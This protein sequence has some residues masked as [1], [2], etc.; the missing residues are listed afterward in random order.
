MINVGLK[1]VAFLYKSELKELNKRMSLY[2]SRARLLGK[3]ASSSVYL[4]PACVAEASATCFFATATTFWGEKMRIVIP[5]I[6]SVAL[7]IF[8]CYEYELSHWMLKHITKGMTVVDVGA[9]IGYHTLLASFLVGD[10]GQVHSFEPTRGTFSILESNAR[11]R[12]NVTLNQKACFSTNTNT[13]LNDFGF[14]YSGFNTLAMP[15]LANLPKR[16]QYQVEALRLDDYISSKQLRPD[17]VKIDAES[18]ELEVLKGMDGAIVRYHP[19][20][21]LEVGDYVRDA[22]SSRMLVQYLLDKD[23]RAFELNQG[24]TVKHVLKKLYDYSN[25]LFLPNYLFSD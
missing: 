11:H 1:E 9:H 19:A 22:V 5:E 21:C 24:F 3:L 16:N 13:V 7:S 12:S 23:Y 10:K 6:S 14:R 20:I 8:G 17:F 4:I 15:R 25:L 2:S 18:T